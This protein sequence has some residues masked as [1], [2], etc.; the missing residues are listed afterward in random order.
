MANFKLDRIRFKWKGAWAP[1]TG[2]T[3]DDIVQHRGSTFVCKNGHTS[4]SEFEAD[5]GVL[6]QEV[7][8]TVARNAGDT[9]NIYRLNGR[10]NPTMYLRKGITYVFNQDDESNVY[11]PNANGSTP[12]P[13][14]L[15]FSQLENGTLV[16]SGFRYLD[17]VRYYLDK[18]PV[19]ADQYVSGFNTA[20]YREVRIDVA[21]DATA[22]YYYCEYHTGMGN[23]IDFTSEIHWEKQNTGSVYKNDWQ[24]GIIYN[25]ND[26]VTY[27]GNIY[28]CINKH[29]SEADIVNGLEADILHWKLIAYV[30]NWRGNW[31]N[32]A[33]Y[34]VNDVVRNNGTVYRCIEAHT[35]AAT[36][37]EGIEADLNKW[38]V[39]FQQVN[40]LQDWTTNVNYKIFDLVKVG[41]S[42]WKCETQHVSTTFADDYSNWSLYLDGLEWDNAWT[43]GVFYQ[44]GDVISYG[45]YQYRAK[46]SNINTRPEATDSATWQQ[47]SENYNFAQDY[48][49]DSTREYRVGDLVRHS[50]YLYVAILDNDNLIEP[51]SPTHW[52]VVVPGR[53]WRGQWSEGRE[54]K[55]EDLATYGSNTYISNGKHLATGSNTPGLD[56]TWSLHVEGAT[57]NVMTTRGDMITYINDAGTLNKQRFARGNSG[58]ILSSLNGTQLEWADFDYVPD[59]YYV[60]ASTGLDSALNGGGTSI[61]S[62]FKT[63]RFACDHILNNR[64][65]IDEFD[66][67]DLGN[68]LIAIA[69]SN[70]TPDATV[71]RGILES[72]N[73]DT[74][75]AFGDITGNGAIQSSDASAWSQYWRKY[76]TNES[77]ND[78]ILAGYEAA[79]LQLHN[80]LLR[81]F[82]SF[83]DETVEASGITYDFKSQ[84]VQDVSVFVSTGV[85]KE[86]L[87]IVVPA[88]TAIIGDEL[89][90]VEVQPA[91]GYEASTMFRV[92]DGSG[93]RNLT[94]S[95][96][97]DTQTPPNQYFT[98]RPLTDACFVTLDPGQGPN[99]EDVWIKTRSPYVQ[100]CT[101][102]GTSVT[103]LKV[104]GNLHNGGNDSIVANDFTQVISDGIGV[105]VTNNARAEL[106]SVFTYYN[107]VGYLAENGGKIRGTNG[108]N[109]YGDF[110]SSAEGVDANETPITATVNNRSGEA[111]VSE[112]LTDGNEILALQYTNAGQ[113]YDNTTTYTFTGAGT[114]AAVASPNVKDGG[115]FQIRLDGQGDNNLGSNYLQVEGNAQDGGTIAGGIVISGADENTLT[116]YQGMRIIILSGAGAGQYGYIDTYDDA[117]KIMGVLKES[118]DSNG[119]DHVV[120]GRTIVAPDSTS[121]YR[122]EP[123]VIVDAPIGGGDTAFVR[124]FISGGGLGE[125]RIIDPGSTYNPASPPNIT[126]I[127]P[128]NTTDGSWT[129]RIGDGV[130]AQPTW[131]NR[132]TGYQSAYLATISGVGYADE[133]PSDGDIVVSNL[134]LLPGPGANL[135]F[136]GNDNLYSVVEVLN[137]TGSAPN[138][139]ASLKITPYLKAITSPAHGT[140]ITIRESY[141]QVR[142]TGHDF[143]DIGTGSFDDTDYPA[144]YLFGYTTDNN[145]DQPSEAVAAGGGRVFYTSTDQDGNFRVGELFKV[146]Q[147]TG[148]ITL[149]ADDFEL[150]GL[151]E[152]RIG[153]IILGGTNAVVREFSTDIN[154]AANS[155]NVVPT[156]KAIKGYIESLIGGGGA[157]L[158]VSGLLAGNITVLNV[159]EIGGSG[160]VVNFE[161]ITNFEEG[162]QGDMLTA[163]LF[164]LK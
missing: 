5:F 32:E 9:G 60:S 141:S 140:D 73:P 116:E 98:K 154:L 69:L 30:D 133:Y 107:H 3:K 1:A 27:N 113:A 84:R 114:G 124:L 136:A 147:A 126:I 119:W 112:I 148:V 157:D 40:H 7:I 77:E 83:K 53:Q 33:R 127:D 28:Q 64:N 16:N 6:D 131:T 79:A 26:I 86:Q 46:L 104:D 121:R 125:F 111:I 161:N 94:M 14:P 36:V 49:F 106:V 11:F 151:T 117:T 66:G 134:T 47:V 71:I 48:S 8:V 90:A 81:Q 22:L 58:Q 128:N 123:R 65:Y 56:A 87:P 137:V 139:S 129:I 2:Y 97:F 142:L 13:H 24:T 67:N 62:P 52:K 50:G 89:R 115:I 29:T 25:Q 59:V 19:T 38:E 44:I 55:I 63:I 20:T 130:L 164:L 132:G 12:N 143:L 57:T 109:S 146:D 35:S 100:N 160:G 153:G 162:V 95:G 68:L 41:A 163:S 101:T 88:G 108:N 43:G 45:G 138:Y 92:R 75:F 105:W 34:I 10:D 39:T 72:T 37:L 96:M 145:P 76:V 158:V 74:G 78:T 156:Q 51:P 21:K 23:D 152:L 15:H 54:Y 17:G 118:D 82:S 149:N 99:D 103:G 42:I 159:N 31:I 155:D 70:P 122:I 135:E 93:I 61:N 85:Y 150:S 144:R 4:Q 102:F 91:E 18:A 110:G 80:E 120:T